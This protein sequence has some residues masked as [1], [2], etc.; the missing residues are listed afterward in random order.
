MILRRSLLPLLAS[1]LF[2]LPLAA[3]APVAPKPDPPPTGYSAIEPLWPAG[4]VPGAVGTD[5]VDVPKLYLYPAAGPGLHPAVVV[6][7][8]GGYTHLVMG[9]EGALEAQW[10]QAHG[11][12]AYV[13]QYRLWPRYQYPYPLLDG[14]RAVRFVR[15]HAAA[16]N[17]RSDAIGIWGFSAGGHM[18][19]YLATAA[20]DAPE[21]ASG[22]HDAI[23]ALSAHP[24]FAILSYARVD[25]DPAIPGTFGMKTL[26]GPTPT[27][28]QLAAVDPIQHITAATSPTFL[29]ATEHDQTVNALNASHFFSAL[30]A[31]GVPAELHIFELGPHGTHMGTD[32]PDY[33]EL[34]ITPTLIQHWLQLHHWMPSE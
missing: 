17:L 29:Y 5:P 3:Q 2:A 4:H 26:V 9:A 33:P 8:G 18:S 19:G 31:V 15:A 6:L 1:T 10:L 23:D 28:A 30:I 16:W 21:N 12:S 11:V 22:S 7:P 27:A 32:K 13:L 20:P 34:A 24:D 25:L 14:L